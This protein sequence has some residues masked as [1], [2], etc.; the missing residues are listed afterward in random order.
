MHKESVMPEILYEDRLQPGCHWS[1][2]MRRGHV[3]RLEDI[4]GGANVGM[5]LYNPYSP[6]ERINI[7]D[8]LK[9]QHTFKLTKGHCIYSDMGRVFCSILEDS[10][11]WHDA[12]SGTCNRR[13]VERRW[14]R[15]TYQQAFNAMHRN[16]LDGF[17]IELAKYGL[18]K[19][20]LAANINFFS[21][22][23]TDAEGNMRY[24]EGASSTCDYVSL[25]FE[26]DTLVVMHSCP[27]PLNPA[28]EWPAKPVGYQILPAEE[29]TVNDICRDSRDE[30]QR[31]FVNNY[32][33]HLGREGGAA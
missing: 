16:G 26:M 3:L 12:A 8:T 19:K 21:Q 5:L 14:G 23:T 7:P 11:G 10:M 2:Q 4:E 17:L 9:A 22:V 24:V 18:G 31:G 30:N 15:K 32:L 27:H 6:L 25:R 28:T 20:D 33:Y 29:P 1:F 13:L